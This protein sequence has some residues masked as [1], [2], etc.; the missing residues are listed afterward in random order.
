MSS[1]E[2]KRIM[3]AAGVPVVPGYHGEDQSIERL[4]RE[5]EM[6]KYIVMV[7]MFL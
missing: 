2:S 6:I 4:K 1:S 3:V 5:A 7:D